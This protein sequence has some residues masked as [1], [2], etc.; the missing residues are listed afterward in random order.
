[1]PMP[2]SFD[3][4]NVRPLLERARTREMSNAQHNAA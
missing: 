3:L 2:E 4:K 1:M